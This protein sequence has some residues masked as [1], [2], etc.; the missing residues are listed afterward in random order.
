MGLHLLRHR[1]VMKSKRASRG[2]CRRSALSRVAL[3]TA[4]GFR[5]GRRMSLS[6]MRLVLACARLTP[7]STKRQKCSK[8]GLSPRLI[9]RL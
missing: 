2:H 1:L 3:W 6:G 7:I 8:A 4:L 9:A 5:F